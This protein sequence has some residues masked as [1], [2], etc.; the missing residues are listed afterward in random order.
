MDRLDY[1]RC[2]GGSAGNACRAPYRPI[3]VYNDSDTQ[4]WTTD[5]RSDYNSLQ[6]QYITR[7]GRGSQFQASYTWAWEFT[8]DASMRDSSGDIQNTSSVTDP[9]N[10]GLDNSDADMYR[11]HVLNGSVIYNL[12]TFAGEGGVKEW[13]GG[14]WAIGGIFIYSSGQPLSVWAATDGGDLAGTKPADIGYD[15]NIRPLSTGASC[16]GSGDLGVLNPAAY[17]LTGW[18][19]GDT[20]QQ[21]KRS[22]C[23]GPDF[24]SVDL[25]VYKNFPFRDRFNVQLRFEMFNIFNTV[26]LMADGVNNTFD[27]EATLDAPRE[28]ATIVTATGAP[29]P[30]FGQATRVRDA[31]QIQLGIKFSF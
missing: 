31:R 15:G 22:E 13:L 2:P 29:D 4:I 25:S 12:P 14:N 24:F 7:F 16:T 28:Q 30:N 1:I 27:A 9:F 17:T 23:E 19:L 26:N 5:G 11:E 6:T 18:R 10:P 8:A 20:S 21:M 3:G